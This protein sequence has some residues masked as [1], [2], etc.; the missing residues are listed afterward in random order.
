MKTECLKIPILDFLEIEKKYGK[1][2]ALESLKKND[3]IIKAASAL[4][5]GKLVAFPTET[6]YGLGAL[7]FLKEAVENIFKVKSRPLD[8]P[9]I[10]HLGSLECLDKWIAYLTKDALKLIEVFWPGP[11]TLILKHKGNLPSFVTSGLDT[12]GIRMPDNL[13]ALSILQLVDSLIAA[14]SANVSGRPSPTLASHVLEDLNGKVDI[15]LDSGP[16]KLG[17]ESTVIDVT[18]EKVCLLRPGFITVEEIEEVLQKKVFVDEAFFKDTKHELKLIAPGLKYKHYAPLADMYLFFCSFENLQQIIDKEKS[19][20]KKIGVLLT[21]NNKCRVEADVYVYYD[22]DYVG[23]PLSISRNL[24]ACF[25]KFDF[26]KVDV[27]YAQ[28]FSEKGIYF[29]IMNRLKKAANY[30]IIR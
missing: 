29:T 5:N 2:K 22:L 18:T 8:N 26:F 13:V 15:I 21:S 7:A 12:V 24:Y 14:P 25:R 27:I 10:L 6:V 30:K 20:G 28:G 1:E 23:N 4:K 11:L 3:A 16:T 19:L 9:L 17:L